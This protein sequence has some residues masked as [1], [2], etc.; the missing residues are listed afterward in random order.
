MKKVMKELRPDHTWGKLV[1]ALV[2]SVYGAS[3]KPTTVYM[4]ICTC[5]G[6]TDLSFTAD[7][8]T[9]FARCYENGYNLNHD[10]RYYLWL[11]K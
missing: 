5:T 6:E 7:E 8:E 2:Y 1:K 10:A 11:H 3:C 4:Y 9:L